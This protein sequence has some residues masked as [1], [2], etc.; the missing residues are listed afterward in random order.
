MK[1]IIF[2]LFVLMS[3]KKDDL[4][5]CEIYINSKSD[6]IKIY[7]GKGSLNDK[8]FSLEKIKMPFDTTII[9][10][11]NEEYF[12]Q[13]NVLKRDSSELNVIIKSKNIY[14]NKYLSE[15]KYQCGN[16]SI[17]YKFKLK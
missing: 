12:F 9:L 3:C 5:F 10:N 8:I 7:L 2:I 11:S 15:C 14:Y 17:E 16:R 6:N 1:K 4:R 13:A